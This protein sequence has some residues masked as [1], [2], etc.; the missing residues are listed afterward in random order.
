[1]ARVIAKRPVHHVEAITKTTPATVVEGV[2]MKVFDCVPARS[3]TTWA[4]HDQIA[5]SIER[6][7]QVGA[8]NHQKAAEHRDETN[9][10]QRC[11]PSHLASSEASRVIGALAILWRFSCT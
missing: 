8:I 5:A 9:P 10:L 3:G 11:W 2:V 7:V 6:S 4:T 1:M